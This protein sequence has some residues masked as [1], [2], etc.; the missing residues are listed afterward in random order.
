MTLSVEDDFGGFVAAR[1]PDLEAVA[2]AA[3]LDP[4]S[5]RDLT[6]ATLAE[7]GGRWALVLEDGAPT[8][9]ARAALLRRVAHRPDAGRTLSGVPPAGGPGPATELLPV[10]SWTTGPDDAVGAA[11]LGALARERPL[12]RA[13]LAAEVAWGV[14]ETDAAV[15]AGDLPDELAAARPAARGRLLT[16]HREALAATDRPPA[17]GRLEPDLADAV[18][19]L[20]A[21]AGDPPDPVG[22]VGA[23]VSRVR[24]RSLVAGGLAVATLGVAGGWLVRGDGP[25]VAP[26]VPRRSGDAPVAGLDDASWWYSDRWPPRGGLAGDAAVRALVARD[27]GPTARLLYAADVEGVRVVV[28]GLLDRPNAAGGSTV[29]AVWSGPSGTPPADLTPLPLALDRIDGSTSV[30]AVAVPRR[31]GAPTPAPSASGGDAPGSERGDGGTVLAALRG[32]RQDASALLVLLSRPRVAVA[33]WSPV[34]HPTSHGSVERTWSI[35]HLEDG[36]ATVPVDAPGA[37]ARLQCEAYDGPVAGGAL[38]PVRPPTPD[39]VTLATTELV[40]SATGVSPARLRTEV[41]LDTTVDGGVLDPSGA[42]GRA[43]AGRV[44]VL[45]TRTPDG[46]TV[47]TVHVSDDGGAG[48]PPLLA[49][50]TVLP[51]AEVDAPVVLAL[52]TAG[53]GRL[54]VV[55][56]GAA[57]CRLVGPEGAGTAT[58]PLPHGVAVLTADG[59]RRPLTLELWDEALRRTY[60]AV[61]PAGRALLDFGPGR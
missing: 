10:P 40:A 14:G 54:L 51:E 43:G 42:P 57:R 37:A 60:A 24:R 13:A 16:A 59:D 2:L 46:A 11:L 35:V 7:L 32:G 18:A 52:P 12:V 29:V 49:P 20:A 5:A 44:L 22:L 45:R 38:V 56:P 8:R 55:A 17:D 23:R 47:R 30:V 21:V 4:R 34:V 27:G 39:G 58:V 31:V 41:V 33:A 3:T 1:W 9:A 25:G 6:A 50:S 61:P 53:A 48:R 36:V 28:A 19:R 26:P 15:A